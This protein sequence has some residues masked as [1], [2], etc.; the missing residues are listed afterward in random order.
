MTTKEMLVALRG[1]RHQCDVA[2]SIG[3]SQSTLCQY[4]TGARVPRDEIKIRI[5]RFY[6]RT[7]EEIFFADAVHSE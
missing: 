5:A 3:V 4:E 2:K 1:D 7:V 6:G